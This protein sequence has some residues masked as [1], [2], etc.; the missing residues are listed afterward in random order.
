MSVYNEQYSCDAHGDV[1]SLE[2]PQSVLMAWLYIEMYCFYIYMF[3]AILYI[4][5]H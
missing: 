5:Y 1:C 3:A 4:S 2:P